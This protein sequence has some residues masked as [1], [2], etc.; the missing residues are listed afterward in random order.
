MF[1]LIGK[2]EESKPGILIPVKYL[3][4]TLPL[5]QQL[6]LLS[7]QQYY[8]TANCYKT[9][10]K[11]EKVFSPII[12][13]KWTTKIHNVEESQKEQDMEHIWSGSI[14]MKLSNRQTNDG[15]KHSELWWG[16]AWEE[17]RRELAGAVITSYL[18]TGVWVIQVYVLV[19]T[20]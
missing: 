6:K 15:G 19:K 20:Q 14:Y 16:T 11:D 3:G 8:V 17:G 5:L 9:F 7:L 13:I 1:Y 10:L 12:T 18:T 2:I 4:K